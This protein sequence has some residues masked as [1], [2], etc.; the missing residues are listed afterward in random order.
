MAEIG[1]G[2]GMTFQT[3][4]LAAPLGWPLLAHGLDQ[5]STGMYT[6]FT[7]NP[8]YTLTNH[9]LQTTGMSPQTAGMLDD[10]ISLFGTLGGT[11]ALKRVQTISSLRFSKPFSNLGNIQ[12][13]FQQGKINIYIWKA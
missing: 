3:G 6:A 12:K 11:A 9:M 8:R 2:A 7:G 13:E 5:F 10:G 4:G 1:A